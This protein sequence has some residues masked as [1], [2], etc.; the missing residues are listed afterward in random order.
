MRNSPF[1]T[2]FCIKAKGACS[3]DDCG[4][5]YGFRDILKILKSPKQPGH[6]EYLDWLGHPFDPDDVNIQFINR[7][8]Q[9]PHSKR[10]S[11]IGY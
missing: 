5:V 6:Q 1:K 3:P 9:S 8:L 2:P 7:V 11:I 4:G 10:N